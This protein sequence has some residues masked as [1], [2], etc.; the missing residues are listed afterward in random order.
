MY[1]TAGKKF[2]KRG[3]SSKLLARGI[4]QKK[5]LVEEQEVFKKTIKILT[6]EDVLRKKQ[7]KQSDLA[8]TQNQIREKKRKL[9]KKLIAVKNGEAKKRLTDLLEAL[10][11]PAKNSSRSSRTKEIVER[12]RSTNITQKITSSHICDFCNVNVSTKIEL[13]NHK[14]MFH[15]EEVKITCENCNLVYAQGI[16]HEKYCTKRNTTIRKR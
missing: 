6:P 14:A 9:R 12:E 1:K 15:F 10:E 13:I 3:S 8:K 5:A 16:N 4:F 2:N 7:K 11:R